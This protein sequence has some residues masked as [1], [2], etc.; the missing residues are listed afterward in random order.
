MIGSKFVRVNL[1]SKVRFK[2]TPEARSFYASYYYS[3]MNNEI[4][5]NID[6]D[7]FAELP[8]FEFMSIFGREISN[9]G[10]IKRMI[11]IEVE[12]EITE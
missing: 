8:I 1:T 7:G 3:K 4:T 10:Y 5:L 9:S 12:M 6:K 2:V 11:P